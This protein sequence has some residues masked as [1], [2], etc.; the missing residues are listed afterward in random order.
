MTT[1]TNGP[2]TGARDAA[3]GMALELLLAMPGDNAS[4][5]F[6]RQIHWARLLESLFADDGGVAVQ[7]AWDWSPAENAEILL[8]LV[9]TTQADFPHGFTIRQNDGVWV[10]ED[11]K[12]HNYRAA[13]PIEDIDGV[14]RHL[15]GLPQ[16]TESPALA[17]KQVIGV[18]SPLPVQEPRKK[19]FRITPRITPKTVVLIVAAMLALRLC[20]LLSDVPRELG[21]NP[22]VVVEATPITQTGYSG[23]AGGVIGLEPTTTPTATVGPTRTP[24]PTATPEGIPLT[25]YRLWAIDRLAAYSIGL[26]KCETS[27]KKIEYDPAVVYTDE[28]VNDMTDCLTT[29]DTTSQ[30]ILEYKIPDVPAEAAEFHAGFRKVAELTGEWVFWLS[31]GLNDGNEFMVITANGKLAEATEVLSGLSATW[32]AAEE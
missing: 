22:K 25:E 14:V 13:F 6:M 26:S 7:A 5:S 31:R 17:P 32:L 21:N 9:T 12:D 2:T 16:E 11:H 3:R 10:A 20:R 30:A 15:L 4:G 27:M 1:Q 18:G 23:G 8:L 19:R 29:V 24:R 28:W